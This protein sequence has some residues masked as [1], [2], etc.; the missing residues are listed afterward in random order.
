MKVST[1]KLS[2]LTLML[3]P[4]P[5]TERYEIVE[6][7]SMVFSMKVDHQPGEDQVLQV[8]FT[9]N[10]ASALSVQPS[11]FTFNRDNWGSDN[12]LTITCLKSP[13]DNT[14]YVATGDRFKLL[15]YTTSPAETF[16]VTPD[17]INATLTKS[18]DQ[19]TLQLNFTVVWTG[20]ADVNPE[21]DFDLLDDKD[22]VL[23]S[24]LA[25]KPPTVKVEPPLGNL[26][27]LHDR[28][29][30]ADNITRSDSR[31]HEANCH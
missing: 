22:N 19:G 20:P 14:A 3:N 6:N 15:Q 11:S 10:P 5:L 8:N 23:I 30:D 25:K 7:E 29:A 21:F 31:C 9:S 28:P 2:P 18:G 17:V 1:A 16:F 24:N 4:S 13:E 12:R 27:T 26:E